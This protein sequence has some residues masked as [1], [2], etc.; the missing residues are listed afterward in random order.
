MFAVAP[1]IP[2]PEL[3]PGEWLNSSRPVRLA[4]WRGRVVLV[5]IWAFT[6]VNCLRSLPYLTAWQLAC[7]HLP[8]SFLGIHSPEFEFAKD[9]RQVEAAVRRLGI[10][11]TVLLYN[12]YRNWDA[13]PTAIGPAS[14]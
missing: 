13:S 3:A 2:A 11:Y 6:R 5:D 10:E 1:R 8:V 7:R 4:A 14:T 12:E 9:R